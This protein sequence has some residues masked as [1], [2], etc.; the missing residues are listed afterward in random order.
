MATFALVKLYRGWI[1]LIG[2]GSFLLRRFIASAANMSPSDGISVCLDVG[3]GHA[4]YRREISRHFG[5]KH[6]FALDFASGDS[7]DVIADAR[8]LPIRDQSIDLVVSFEAL[9]AID[10]Y[11]AVLDEI[12]RVLRPAGRLIVSFRFV[13]GEG[14]VVDFRRWTVAGMAQDL[15]D[16]GF[17]VSRVARLGG[18]LLVVTY[19]MIWAIQNIVP[20]LRVTWRSPRTVRAY[21][22][23]GLVALLTFPLLLFSWLALAADS[24][25]P[26]MG[27]YMGAV[28]FAR[29]GSSDIKSNQRSPADRSDVLQA[30]GGTAPL[31]RSERSA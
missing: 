15:E 18:V 30:L 6:Y 14:G 24:L 10:R 5:V 27:C 19:V 4:P 25:L 22:R 8:A 3:A 16:H 13:Y 9:S 26:E 23:E 31:G 7:V 17:I 2:P 11:H 29:L 21:C 20:G 1:K 12:A 28:M